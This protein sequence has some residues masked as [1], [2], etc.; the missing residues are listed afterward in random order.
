MT[1]LFFCPQSSAQGIAPSLPAAVPGLLQEAIVDA[2]IEQRLAKAPSY[3][4]LQKHISILKAR[5]DA[6]TKEDNAAN[7]RAA[8]EGVNPETYNRDLFELNT[9]LIKYQDMLKRSRIALEPG[10]RRQV[11]KESKEA[12]RQR[13]RSRDEVARS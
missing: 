10:I 2:L 9:L 3:A 12:R 7:R 8:K 5:I 11:E 13:T 1:L 4:R 6:A